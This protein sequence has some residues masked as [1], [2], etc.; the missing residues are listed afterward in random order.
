VI[1]ALVVME[2]IKEGRKEAVIERRTIQRKNDM[3][4]EKDDTK[5]GKG[6]KGGKKKEEL[7]EGRTI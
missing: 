6:Y 7:Y 5:E 4:E 1:V 2:D 3:K